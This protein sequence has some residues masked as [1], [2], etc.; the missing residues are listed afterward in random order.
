MVYYLTFIS[1]KIVLNTSKSIELINITDKV[2]EIVEKSGVDDALVNISTKHTTSAVVINED[3]KGLKNDVV[4]LLDKIIPNDSYEH[5][6]IDNNA[7]SHLM[8]LLLSSNQTL[9]VVGGRINLGT[10]QSIFFLELD[11]PRSNR[12]VNVS[13][14]H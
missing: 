9:P 4:S 1:D 6:L 11:G 12:I 7:R 10:W 2:Q 14:L 8:S 13:I 3:E 5:D